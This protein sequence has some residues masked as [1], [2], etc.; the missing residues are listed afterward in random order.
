[1]PSHPRSAGSS[2]GGPRRRSTRAA[3]RPRRTV[4]ARRSRSRRSRAATSRSRR[5]RRTARARRWR[6]ARRGG[7][8]PRMA[9]AA[10]SARPRRAPPP[11]RDARRCRRV[12]RRAAD[13]EVVARR[14]RIAG[15]DAGQLRRLGP[16]RVT[17]DGVAL[18]PPQHAL[19]RSTP[20]LRRSTRASPSRRAGP[21]C[22]AA[23]M[24]VGER[25]DLD[26]LASTATAR[27]ARL[28]RGGAQR[29]P[30]AGRSP[31]GRRGSRTSV[32]ARPRRDERQILDPAVLGEEVERRRPPIVAPRRT[33]M[34]RTV[35]SRLGKSIPL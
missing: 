8:A 33:R 34:R 24:F 3:G 1:M 18:P 10:S 29:G 17:L 16:W 28:R 19:V 2:R 11:P 35:V 32:P 30:S 27:A 26:L 15:P 21:A 5:P 31:A 7:R 20:P 25:D 22:A 23:E 14:A 9:R 6:A 12:E 13:L 4:A